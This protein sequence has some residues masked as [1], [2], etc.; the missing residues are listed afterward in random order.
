MSN[1][2]KKCQNAK[3]NDHQRQED[4]T[5]SL[6][7]KTAMLVYSIVANMFQTTCLNK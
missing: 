4:V 3:Q 1:A 2:Y 5:L 7:H 6:Q